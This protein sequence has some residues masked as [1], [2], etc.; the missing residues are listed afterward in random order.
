MPRIGGRDDGARYEKKQL[1]HRQPAEFV[2]RVL[3]DFNSGSLDAATAAWHLGVSRAR[4]YQL[5]SA[6][7]RLRDGYEP[8]ASG[9][10]R[11]GDWPPESKTFLEEF[12]PL[13]NQPNY[14]LVAD[15]LDR[16]CGVVRARSSVDA[17]V[18]AHYAHLVPTPQRKPRVH[19]RFRRA[20]IGELPASSGAALRATAPPFGYLASF[21]P[22]REQRP[23]HRLRRPKLRNLRDP[24]Q[25]RHPPP[26]SQSPLLGSR[27]SSK[28]HL[29]PHSRPFY[30][31]ITV[32]FC[33]GKKSSFEP[34]PTKKKFQ[35]DW[36]GAF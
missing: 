4:L 25:V 14:Q 28:G 34:S 2:R 23:P 5:R 31:V 26:P 18:T 10:D 11:R 6:F 17:H 9:G 29:A 33:S 16:L 7:L 22:P 1:V 36:R 8:M 24:P 19:R 27:T 12:L 3:S 35:I 32:W 21:P 13:Q 15:E 20:R 30:S